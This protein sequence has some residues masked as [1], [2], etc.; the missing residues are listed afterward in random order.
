MK[1]DEGNNTL[2]VGVS[3]RGRG[4]PK[5]SEPVGPSDLSENQRRGVEAE[6]T[7]FGKVESS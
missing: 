1:A 3:K 2:P 4:R 7:C 5:K 6:W